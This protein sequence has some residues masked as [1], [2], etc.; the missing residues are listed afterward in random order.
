MNKMF[1]KELRLSSNAQLIVFTALA[2]LMLIPSFPPAA[3]FIYTIAGI[4]TV[5]PRWLANHDIEYSMLLPVRKADIVRGKVAFTVFYELL[6]MVVGALCVLI[7]VF[8]IAPMIEAQ[9]GEISQFDILTSPTIG[10]FGFIFLAGG[11]ANLILFPLYFR[12]PFKRLTMPPLLAI[13]AYIAIA[14]VGTVVI[15]YVPVFRSYETD[16]LI[17]QCLT[18]CVGA[19]AFLFITWLGSHISVK[20]FENIDL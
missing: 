16:G 4:A 7:R 17:T 15:A 9:G 11:I 12:N 3:P 18:L 8:A 6:A 13:F 20:K 10:L 2:V 14:V 5:F 1:R 19:L